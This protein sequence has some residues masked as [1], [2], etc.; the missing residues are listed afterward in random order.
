MQDDAHF[1]RDEVAKVVQALIGAIKG[2]AESP[3]SAA[4]LSACGNSEERVQGVIDAAQRRAFV[5]AGFAEARFG[6]IRLIYQDYASDPEVR[7]AVEYLCGTEEM[8]LNAVLSRNS[9]G[10]GGGGNAAPAAG[11]SAPPGSMS[12]SM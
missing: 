4:Q 10:G 12:M 7:K 2:L 11:G 8:F 1:S 3:E 5:A 9:G 6:D